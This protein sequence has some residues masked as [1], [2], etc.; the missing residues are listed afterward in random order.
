[1][2]AIIV[3]EKCTYIRWKDK[4]HQGIFYLLVHLSTPITLELVPSCVIQNKTA[5]LDVLGQMK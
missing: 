4:I 2:L 1:M 5:T 3:V